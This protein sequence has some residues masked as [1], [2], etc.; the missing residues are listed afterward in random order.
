MTEGTRAVFA[1]PPFAA[2]EQSVVQILAIDRGTI[3]GRENLLPGRLVLDPR[4]SGA[5]NIEAIVTSYGSGMYV[6]DAA[7]GRGIGSAL[8]RHRE[9]I[10]EVRLSCGVSHM[11][12]PIYRK[13]GWQEFEM[14]RHLMLR[15]ARPVVERYV[16][17]GAIGWLGTVAGNAALHVPQSLLRRRIARLGARLR[18]ERVDEFP[19]ECVGHL[20]E[21]RAAASTER[22]VATIH[23]MLRNR[24][25]NDRHAA[26]SLSIVRDAKSDRPLGYFLTK[27]RFHATASHRNFRNVLLGSLQDWMSFPG[28]DI[29]VE[30]FALLAIEELS[31]RNVSAIEI[32][33]PP[34]EKGERLRPLG[35][36]SL[37]SQLFFHSAAK[38]SPLAHPRFAD[39]A[40]W[41]IRPADGDNIFV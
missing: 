23:W 9:Q 31:A 10:H 2:D 4:T 34:T 39:P 24:F 6:A 26:Q 36:R 30:D 33:V 18:A 19:A 20:A 35:F 22:S 3:I 27:V 38:G 15:D 13:L 28:A 29:S 5:P 14:E 17:N 21:P 8:A 40:A 1:H 25:P 41:W 11:L 7:R 12:A 32:C 16:G 37:G